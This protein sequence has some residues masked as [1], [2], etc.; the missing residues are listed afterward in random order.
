MRSHSISASCASFLWDVPCRS[1]SHGVTSDS[2][3]SYNC[4]SSVPLEEPE[5]DG[6]IFA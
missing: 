6:G 5:S 4:I 3:D 2:E 1:L